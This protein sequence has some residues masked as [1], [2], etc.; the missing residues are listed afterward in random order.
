MIEYLDEDYIEIDDEIKELNIYFQNTM[1]SKSLRVFSIVGYSLYEFDIFINDFDNDMI[2]LNYK[3]LNEKLGK[4]IHFD[5]VLEFNKGKDIES[6][7]YLRYYK[8]EKDV[9]I[10]KVINKFKKLLLRDKKLMVSFEYYLMKYHNKKI[11]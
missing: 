2:I 7:I 11:N 4:V 6:N 3:L 8:L 1:L 9:D 5:I 10:F